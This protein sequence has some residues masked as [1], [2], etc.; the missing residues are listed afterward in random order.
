MSN[1]FDKLGVLNWWTGRISNKE[2][3]GWTGMTERNV[4]YTLVRPGIKNFISGGGRGS[5]DRRR[6]AHPAR[7]AVAIVNA[8]RKQGMTIETAANILSVVPG[9]ASF[10]S[11]VIDFE[12]PLDWPFEEDNEL[13]ELMEEDPEGGWD[14]NDVVPSHVFN[15]RCYPMTKED[16][17][18]PAKVGDVAWVPKTLID[19]FGNPKGMKKIGPD[20]YYP[21]I[22]PLGFYD[23]YE[24][25]AFESPWIDIKFYI[26]DGKW[27]F[28]RYAENAQELVLYYDT[29]KTAIGM[30]EKPQLSKDDINYA[31]VPVASISE[32]G[33]VLSFDEDPELQKKSKLDLHHFHTKL[34]VNASLAIRTMKRRAY[35][36]AAPSD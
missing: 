35:G 26:I 5:K 7:N 21:D 30:Q 20:Q 23:P 14:L 9:I 22:D 13:V 10:P 36:L 29:I 27:V 32:N 19:D 17:E 25:R 15:R 16:M 31:C 6:L 12:P 2:L 24:S 28:L 33:K 3:S 11:D 34:E 4:Q 8:L 1:E 18:M